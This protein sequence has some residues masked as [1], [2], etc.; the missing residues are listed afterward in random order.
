M[1]G[2]L[3]FE[4]PKEMCDEYCTVIKIELEDELDLYVGTGGGIK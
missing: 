2:V 3:W 1:P 4:L